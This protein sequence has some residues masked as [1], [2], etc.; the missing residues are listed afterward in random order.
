MLLVARVPVHFVTL[1]VSRMCGPN[2]VKLFS[3][4]VKEIIPPNSVTFSKVSRVCNEIVAL[5]EFSFWSCRCQ[6]SSDL[7]F[8]VFVG[9][10]L[11][12]T[13]QPFIVAL[14]WLLK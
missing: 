4:V 8:Q 13:N 12:S 1:N 6:C 14:R 3:I 11:H 10:S 9:V 2:I 7:T 5:K